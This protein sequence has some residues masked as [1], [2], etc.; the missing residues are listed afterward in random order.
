MTT[1]YPS[2]YDTSAAGSLNTSKANDNEVVDTSIDVDANEINTCHGAVLA[3]EQTVGIDPDGT[4]TVDGDS[5]AAN[6]QEVMNYLADR[7]DRA[8]F[9]ETFCA[10][11]TSLPA[12]TVSYYVDA[13]AG[14]ANPAFA[15]VAGAS[16]VSA[17]TSGA[18]A[19]C[20]LEGTDDHFHSRYTYYRCMYQFSTIAF[21]PWANG[22]QID[23][24]L[25]L[26]IN[27]YVRFRSTAAGGVFPAYTYE[28]YDDGAGTGSVLTGAA[29]DAGTWHVAEILSTTTGAYFFIDR[30]GW[31]GNTEYSSGLYTGTAP[32]NGQCNPFISIECAAG[33]P[34]GGPPRRQNTSVSMLSGSSSRACHA[35]AISAFTASRRRSTRP[36]DSTSAT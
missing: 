27:N 26:D 15:T 5:D 2:G 17:Q 25:W 10:S 35:S 1:S 4:L 8:G 28:I 16:G 13:I 3:L 11:S 21:G 36:R 23:F 12:N 24:G 19:R 14:G 30:G 22:D 20:G 7:A 18:A 33:G 32:D 9:N 6:I 31:N 29:P 34:S